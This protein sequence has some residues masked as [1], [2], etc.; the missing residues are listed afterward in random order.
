MAIRLIITLKTLHE[1]GFIS[2]FDSWV[3]PQLFKEITTAIFRVI[4]TF[5]VVIV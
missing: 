1:Q 3:K 2:D 4:S 5:R